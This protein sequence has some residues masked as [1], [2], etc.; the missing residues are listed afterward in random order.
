MHTNRN[1]KRQ[2]QSDSSESSLSE[3]ESEFESYLHQAISVRKKTTAKKPRMPKRNVVVVPKGTELEEV[4]KIGEEQKKQWEVLQNGSEDTV[5][6]AKKDPNKLSSLEAR[7]ESKR[8]G[9]ESMKVKATD[10]T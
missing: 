9:E 8:K 3:S 7:Y 2:K 1:K 4:Q 5:Q 6:A 10:P